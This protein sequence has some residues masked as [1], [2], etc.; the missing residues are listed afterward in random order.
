MVDDQ[1]LTAMWP[2]SEGEQCPEEVILEVEV[3]SSWEESQGQRT[4][5]DLDHGS[6]SPDSQTAHSEYSDYGSGKTRTY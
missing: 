2:P 4:L 3:I 5:M 6:H 1:C